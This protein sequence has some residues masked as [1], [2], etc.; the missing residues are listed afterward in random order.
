[1]P[2]P[3]TIGP[4]S[5]GSPPE[6]AGLGLAFILP[7]A[8]ASLLTAL[9]HEFGHWAAGS[10]LGNEMAMSLNTVHA[11]G[12]YS[13]DWHAPVVTAAG[14]AV[15]LLQAVIAHALLRRG[16]SAWAFAFLLVPFVYR[17]MA[18]GMNVVNPNDEGR[19]SAL[20]GLGLYTLPAMVCALLL[21]LV[22]DA[23]RRHEYRARAVVLAS[24][25]IV[26]LLGMLI[27]LDQSVELRLL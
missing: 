14:P 25:L 7:A 13:V 9:V 26:H 18:L 8:V 6:K 10:L 2:N 24:I 4:R 27:L 22:V 23:A 21:W 17:L 19:L 1:M 11:V 12:G 16:R 3:S 5:P 20:M 15:T